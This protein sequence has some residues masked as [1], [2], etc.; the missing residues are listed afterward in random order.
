MSSGCSGRPRRH[1]PTSVLSR[2]G[3]EIEL[4]HKRYLSLVSCSSGACVLPL[5]SP[6]PPHPLTAPS[7]GADTLLASEAFPPDPPG[8][9][10]VWAQRASGIW[11]QGGR[12]PVGWH[13]A[14]LKVSQTFCQSVFLRGLVTK[15]GLFPPRGRRDS[16]LLSFWSLDFLLF[17]Q[18][19]QLPSLSEPSVP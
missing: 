5:P 4:E 9:L 1:K 13:W 14:C 15:D 7:T 3:R 17:G 2:E 16:A 10:R 12:S 11:C 8:K 6:S 18:R 19:A